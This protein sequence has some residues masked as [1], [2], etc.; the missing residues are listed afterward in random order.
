MPEKILIVD[1]D[2]DTLKLVGLILQRHGYGIVAANGGVS[3]LAKANSERP[4]LILLDL[5]MPDLDGYEVARRLRGDAALAHIPIIMFTAKTMLDDKVA[6]FEAGADDYL[7]KP[8]HPSELIAHVKALLARTQSARAAA[9]PQAAFVAGFIGAKGGVGTTTLAVNFAASA[10]QAGQ[11]V[12]LVDLNPGSG[13][14]ALMLG[15]SPT[16]SLTSLLSKSVA[17]LNQRTLA[18]YIIAHACGVRILAG[19]SLPSEAGL[20]SSVTQWETMLKILGTMC[21]LLVLDLG[22]GLPELTRRI[23]PSVGA[24]VVVADPTRLSLT[25]ARTLLSELANLG[26]APGR[27]E[28]AMVN[29]AP[30]STQI[31]IQQAEQLVGHKVAG[32]VSPAAELAYQAHEV[33]TPMILLRPESLTADQLRVISNL[34]MQKVRGSKA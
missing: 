14:A 2:L 32:V 21:K 18:S 4:D 25:Q 1:D 20:L 27:V 10:A 16:L 26:Q 13:A 8:T 9:A 15:I 5:M 19:Q 29:R 11:E 24:L 30:S 22:T 28:V 7:T 12:L 3:A 17:E 34:V 23:L 31:S 33:G 6:G